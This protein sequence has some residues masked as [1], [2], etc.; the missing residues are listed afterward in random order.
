MGGVKAPPIFIP[1]WRLD[2]RTSRSSGPG[3]QGVNKTESKVEIRFKIE[4]ADWIPFTARERLKK[5]AASYITLDGELILSSQVHRSQQQNYNTC[6][7]K[8]AQLLEKAATPPKP[9][10]AT[11]ATRGS[12]ERRLKSKSQASAKKSSRRWRPSDD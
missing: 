10:I 6:L 9:R 12:K 2:T 4:D 1:R 5:I 7:E 3:G 8:L 11:R